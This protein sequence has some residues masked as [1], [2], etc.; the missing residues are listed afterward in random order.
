VECHEGPQDGATIHV[1][2][3]L[4]LPETISFPAGVAGVHRHVYKMFA[5]GEGYTEYIYD[6]LE[7]GA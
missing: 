5:E 6:R 3:V 1:A 2:S 4:K 7:V